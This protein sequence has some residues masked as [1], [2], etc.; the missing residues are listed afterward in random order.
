MNVRTAAVLVLVVATATPACGGTDPVREA[1]RS[2]TVA[3]TADV[4]EEACPNVRAEYPNA[5]GEWR[6]SSKAWW[7]RAILRELGYP[8]VGETGSALITCIDGQDLYVWA[9]WR[10]Y[11]DITP[12]EPG[13]ALVGKVRGARVYASSIRGAWHAQNLTVWVEVGPTSQRLPRLDALAPLVEATS[14]G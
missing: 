6:A 12:P 11:E 9:T 4:S 8:L 5:A 2:A 13:M 1:R 7:L 10:D 3:P 14:R